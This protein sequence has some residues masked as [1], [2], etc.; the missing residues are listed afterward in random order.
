MIELPEA[1]TLAAQLN[2]SVKGKR[3][4]RVIAAASPHKFSWFNGD[5]Q[6]YGELLLGKIMGPATGYGAMVEIKVEDVILVFGDGVNLRYHAKNAPRPQKHQLLIEFQEG[7]ALSA[8]V[9]MYGGL[10]CAREGEFDNRYY[11]IAQEKPSP[12]TADFSAAYF[13]QMLAAPEVQGLSAKACLATEQR[14]PGLGNGVLQD[15]LYQAKI[16]PKRKVKLLTDKERE[17]LFRAV[18]TTLKEMAAHGG[19][20]TETGLYGHSGGYQTRVSKNTLGKPCPACG[21]TIKKEAYLG[22]SIYFCEGCQP[23]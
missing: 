20:D 3:I 23:V 10:W 18:K 15:I 16:H 7:E 21:T 8:A 22:G 11:K 19:R 12:L 5:P 13:S 17:M 6:R 4:S 2:D 14:I 1:V 9:Q